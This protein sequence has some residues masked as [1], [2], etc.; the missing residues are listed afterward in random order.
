[1]KNYLIVNQFF[2]LES[3]EKI[4]KLLKDAF[5][6][7]GQELEIITNT[8]ARDLAKV[9]GNGSKILFWDKDVFLATLLEKSGYRLINSARAVEICDDKAKTYLQLLNKVAMPKTII[10]PFVYDNYQYGDTGFL[11][12]V[13]KELGFPLVVKENK[14]SFGA[15]VYLVN[16]I[17]E[18]KNLVNSIGHCNILFQEFISGS[19]GKDFRVYI[20]GGKVVASALRTND[21]DFRSNI[22]SG[23]KMKKVE[24]DKNYA[25]IAL[26]ACQEIGVDFAGVDLLIGENG[27]LVC[28]VN[29]NA[30]FI[31][32]N[33][34]SGVNIALEIAKYFLITK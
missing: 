19:A 25:E 24:L 14:G 10:A 30:H 32:L 6:N 31:A 2:C 27:P 9:N 29:S 12:E 1:M 13:A 4:Y 7:L 20:V 34:V 11:N 18:L 15:Q 21:K 8:Q 3:F 28:E 22:A 17:T 33:E 16:D 5:A 23:G 26:K